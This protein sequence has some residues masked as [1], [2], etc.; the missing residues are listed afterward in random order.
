[1]P[2]LIATLQ[3]MQAQRNGVLK[4]PYMGITAGISDVRLAGSAVVSMNQ[5]TA[6][7]ATKVAVLA[8]TWL[9]EISKWIGGFMYHLS[10]MCLG[11][12]I[13]VKYSTQFRA[14]TG[15]C[16]RFHRRVTPPR[17][18]SPGGWRRRR[19]HA[20]TT[21]GS[22]ISK[23]PSTETGALEWTKQLYE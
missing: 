14:S 21:N 17:L 4:R 18:K 12:E 10:Y 19:C 8:E 11:F 3:P 1:M 13:G 6:A 23:E 9:W 15:G 22:G 16:M 7:R 5:C 2:S 20:T